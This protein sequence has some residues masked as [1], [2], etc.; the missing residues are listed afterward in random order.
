VP[1][2]INSAAGQSVLQLSGAER[3]M[4]L[5]DNKASFQLQEKDI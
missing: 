4:T 5:E 3:L 2:Q 1:E